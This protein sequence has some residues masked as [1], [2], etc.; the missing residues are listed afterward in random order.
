VLLRAAFDFQLA[1]HDQVR[2]YL[3]ENWQSSRGVQSE[4]RKRQAILRMLYHQP[5]ADADQRG[6]AL[7]DFENLMGCP[8][9]HLE[10][11]L[12]CC[13]QAIW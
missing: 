9:E 7:R 3:F 13:V 10:F 4:V 8:R 11:S 5:F 1:S 2:L 12:W 6:I